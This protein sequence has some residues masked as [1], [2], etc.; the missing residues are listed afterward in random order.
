MQ[1]AFFPPNQTFEVQAA[2]SSWSVQTDD[3]GSFSLTIQIAGLSCSWPAEPVQF[4]VLDARL[5]ILDQQPVDLLDLVTGLLKC[6][7]L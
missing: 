3:S 5:S 6:L 2:G 1:G 4:E 7:G